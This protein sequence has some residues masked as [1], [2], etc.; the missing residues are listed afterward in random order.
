MRKFALTAVAVASLA[1]ATGCA[2]LGRKVF[3]EPV[4]SFREMRVTGLG[5]AGGSLDVVLSVYNPNSYRLD[6]TRL[7]YNLIVDSIPFGN[8]AIDQTFA[9][10]SGD[11]TLVRLPVTFT[12]AGIGSAGRSLLNTGTVN[13]RVTGDVTVG[14]PLGNFTRPYDRA[15]RYTA[16]GGS[17]SR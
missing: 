3:K 15:G 2:T 16:L 11:S 12:Y 8:G 13:Y 6:A 9:V 10:Q 4:V 17:T 7:T 1:T 14:T 5:L